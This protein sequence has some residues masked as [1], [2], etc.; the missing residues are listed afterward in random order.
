MSASAKVDF[1]WADG[2][3]VFRLPIGPAIELEEKCAAGLREIYTRLA[4]GTWR[5][6]DLRETLRLGLIGGGLAPDAALRLVRRYVDERPFEENV[7][8]A[9]LVLMAALVGVPDDQ[10]KAAKKKAV[11]PGKAK[12][13]PAKAPTGSPPANSTAPARR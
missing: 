12:R 13:R 3:Y 9:M 7:R 10:P 8:P 1:D 6:A 5:I 11:Q 4:T 2:H